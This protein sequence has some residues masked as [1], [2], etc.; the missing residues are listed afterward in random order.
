MS[1][2]TSENVQSWRIPEFNNVLKSF[3]W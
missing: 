2:E 3:S 1:N